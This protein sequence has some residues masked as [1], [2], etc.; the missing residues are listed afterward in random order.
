M[1]RV[2]KLKVHISSKV[3]L[4]KHRDRERG[5]GALQALLCPLLSAL[6]SSSGKLLALTLSQIC[7]N[8]NS[9]NVLARYN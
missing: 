9:R 2:S 8:L 6:Q 7:E 1:H 3:T 4:G 5:T